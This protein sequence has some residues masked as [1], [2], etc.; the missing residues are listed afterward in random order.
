MRRR[1]ERSQEWERGVGG[2]GFEGE[3]MAEVR[4]LKGGERKRRQVGG[5]A[6]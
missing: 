4:G 2:R 3:E 5:R 6:W 1:E